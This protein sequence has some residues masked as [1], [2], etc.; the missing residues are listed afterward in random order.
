MFCFFFADWPDVL[1]TEALSLEQP[2]PGQLE[3]TVTCSTTHSA[4]GFPWLISYFFFGA[5]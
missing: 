4:A 5:C 1:G 3:V 2:P